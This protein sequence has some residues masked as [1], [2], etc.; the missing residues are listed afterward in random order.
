MNWEYKEILLSVSSN[1]KETAKNVKVHCKD[2]ETD[3]VVKCSREGE[4]ARCLKP[5]RKQTLQP[6]T[7]DWPWLEVQ[8]ISFRGR[9]K[10][11]TVRLLYAM[12]PNRLES[13]IASFKMEG[14]VQVN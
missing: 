3:K 4:K 11:K 10:Q 9:I 1:V 5:P 2:T 8:V 12:I 7:N 6:Q 13:I 14:N